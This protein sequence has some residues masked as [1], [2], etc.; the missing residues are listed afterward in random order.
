MQG[1]SYKGNHYTIFR[2]FDYY[3]VEDAYYFSFLEYNN[4]AFLYNICILYK[5]IMDLLKKIGAG[6]RR[7]ISRHYRGGLGLDTLGLNMGGEQNNDVQNQDKNP[8]S[9]GNEKKEP[10]GFKYGG[11]GTEYNKPVNTVGGNADAKKYGGRKSRRS[12]RKS[13]RSRRGRSYRR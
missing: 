13:R 11:Q 1:R 10:F 7:R 5:T 3:F 8:T 9:G 6:K 4:L 12:G 2:V